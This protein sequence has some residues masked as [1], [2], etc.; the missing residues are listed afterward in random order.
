MMGEKGPDKKFSFLQETIKS[1]P[2][3]KKELFY[4]LFRLLIAGVIFGAIAGF[5]F[6]A[7]KSWNGKSENPQI[8]IPKDEEEQTPEIEDET[9][10]VG[11]I[12]VEVEEEEEVEQR[13]KLDLEN[14]RELSLVLNQIATDIDKSIVEIKSPAI[15]AEWI[16]E[17][18][19]TQPGVSGVIFNNTDTEF[20]IL[21]SSIGLETQ[22]EFLI[23]FCDG[24]SVRGTLCQR[25]VNMELMV[26][27]VS[28]SE[29]EENTLLKLK[30]STLGNSNVLSRGTTVIAAGR[31]FGYEG[32]AYGMLSSVKNKIAVTDGEY[33]L[34]STDIVGA[35]NGNAILF[36]LNGEVIGV[37]NQRLTGGANQAVMSAL[38]ISNIKAEIEMLSNEKPIP[39]IG[40]KGTQVS[41]KIADEQGMPQGIYV[42]DVEQNSP[43]LQ[44]GIKSGDVVIEISGTDILT[45]SDYRSKLL[46]YSEGNVIRLTI[47]RRGA[48]EY[49]D[50]VL[51]ITVGR[52]NER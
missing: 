40:I 43:A 12:E 35:K 42:K 32:I 46:E 28:K 48:E 1:E 9:E 15:N 7:V 5:T 24:T 27:M 14:Y 3:T 29:I 41:E 13:V 19:D 50:I 34:L 26:L 52:G 44:A 45:M 39:Y 23:T 2:F 11:E 31:P 51:S 20:F 8:V 49:V 17:F 18:Y 10:G 47:M 16:G 22:E 25:D 4:M 30:E 6:G 38:A 37:V 21:S 33:K 36:N